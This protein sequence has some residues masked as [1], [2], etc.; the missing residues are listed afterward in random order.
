MDISIYLAIGAFIISIISAVVSIMVFYLQRR[1]LFVNSIS[2]AR[3]EYMRNLTDL[4]ALF[5]NDCVDKNINDAIRTG[6]KIRL[7]FSPNNSVH[8]DL[9]DIMDDCIVQLEKG[10]DPNIRALVKQSQV[11]FKHIWEQSKA[12][13]YSRKFLK[14]KILSGVDQKQFI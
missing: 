4:V 12:E 1:T 9:S 2:K 8:R 14:N 7:H 10:S 13:S 5:I 3:P 6:Y 11:F